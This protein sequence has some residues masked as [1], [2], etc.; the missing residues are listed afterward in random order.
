[1]ALDSVLTTLAEGFRINLD[2]S[3]AANRLFTASLLPPPGSLDDKGLLS[4]TD[5]VTST[6][7]TPAPL[8]LSWRSKDV[9]FLNTDITDGNVLG[10]L[11]INDLLALNV[12]TVTSGATSPPGVPGLLGLLSGTIPLPIEVTSPT[13]FAVTV[14]VRWRVRDANGQPVDGVS[15]SLGGTSPVSG[16][17]SDIA[18][19]FGSALALL[20]L[21]FDLIFAELTSNVV[22]LA[23]R[24]L[25]ASVRLQAAGVSTG[26]I[27]LPPV[28]L[29]L[30]VIPVP[31]V[32]IFCQDSNFRSHKLVV[33]PASSPLD[34]GTVQ[35]AVQTLH[36]TLAPLESTFSFLGIFLGAAGTVADL[37]A[38]TSLAFR[39]ADQLS[40]LNDIDLA[41]GFFNDTE[42]EDELSSMILLGPPHRRIQGFNARDFST[43]EGEI[44]VTVGPEL[45]VQIAS[46]HSNSP[47]SD[48]A[49]R[50]NVPFAPTGSRFLFHDITSFGDELSSLRFAWEP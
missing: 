37:L 11:P 14:D 4:V 8:D 23:Q 20:T 13:T 1:M 28:D 38:D 15:W 36:D 9:R 24:R 6:Q 42:A 35:A 30:P 32:A 22:P 47:A 7:I 17:G 25:E 2:S 12:G 16:T 31:T 50:V 3:G 40:N 34:Q 27:D 5:L 18:P 26:W 19:P 21:T 10:G 48:P 44:D 49:G 45:I 29:Q 46:L 33:I 41:S 43:S 39:K